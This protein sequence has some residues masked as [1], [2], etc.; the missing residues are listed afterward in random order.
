MINKFIMFDFMCP[1][2]SFLNHKDYNKH[3]SQLEK[4]TCAQSL[5]ACFWCERELKTR[6]DEGAR[7]VTGRHQGTESFA[8]SR[9]SRRA[10]AHFVTNLLSHKETY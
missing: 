3:F 1:V 6:V 8:S 5:F 9:D 10:S 7:E 2:M 4:Q